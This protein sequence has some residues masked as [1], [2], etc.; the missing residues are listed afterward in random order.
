MAADASFPCFMV[1]KDEAGNVYGRRRV[2]HARRLAAGRRADRSRLFVAQLQRRA[3]RARASGRRAAFPHVPGIDCA[4]TVVESTSPQFKPGDEVLVTG[5]EFGAG[6]WGGYSQ[7]VRVPAEWIVPLPAGLTLRE[8][9]IYGTAGFTAAQC[10]TAIVERGI[11]PGSRAGRRHRRHRRRRLARRRDSRQAR[12]RGGRRH[13]QSRSGTTGC[14]N[15]A[16]QRFSTAT[17]CST[18]PTGRCSRSAGR[19][20]STRSAAS[21]WPRSCVRRISR[22]VAACG[23]VG[24][25]D[26]PLSVYPFILRGVTLAGI[27]SA[28]CPRPQRLEMWQKLAGPWRV[29]N[30][31]RLADEVDARRLAG[32]RAADSRRRD[33]RPHARRADVARVVR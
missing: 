8:T 26:L 22:F 5:Y 31:E 23:L 10:V 20:R 25:T 14:G 21:R 15:W 2:D 12:L 1:R 4:G 3:G 32:P 30:L 24:G 33:R 6:H 13:R 11:E 29:D 9:M 28:K 16:R 18:R 17:T 27:D 7:F 19:R